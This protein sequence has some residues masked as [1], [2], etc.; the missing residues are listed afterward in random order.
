MTD[1]KLPP[2]DTEAEQ[3]VL[4][5]ILIDPD[6]L[7]KVADSLFPEHFYTKSH[8]VVYEAM[9]ELFETRQPTDVLTL[10]AMLEKNGKLKAAGGVGEISALVASVP[11][12]ANIEHYA[13]LVR[14]QYIKRSLITIGTKVAE[15]GY[16]TKGEKAETL[17]ENAEQ[18]I[19]SITQEQTTQAFTP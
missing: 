5:S 8:Q 18:L 17:L 9:L 7:L 3:S 2:Q 13:N 19:F 10:R 4:G 15:M 16:E 11:T 14:D 1:A 6:A 12:S